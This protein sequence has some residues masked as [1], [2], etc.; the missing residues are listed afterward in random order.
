MTEVRDTCREQLSA[1]KLPA[2]GGGGRQSRK[3]LMRLSAVGL[4]LTITL[5]AAKHVVA[6]RESGQNPL[7][8]LP[9]G[10]A[11]TAG[12]DIGG[13]PTDYTLQ[14]LAQSNRVDGVVNIGEPDVAEQVAAASLNMAYMHLPMASGAAP[15]RI[16]LRTL[17][18][19]MR[20]HA[21]GGACVYLHDDAGGGRAVATAGMLLLLRGESWR[22]VRREMT[23]GELS[24]L[25]ASQ[26]TAVEQLTSA[27]HSQGHSQPGNPYS[28]SRV[29]PW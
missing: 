15:T 18:N 7:A 20:S 28:D 5:V 27:L 25:S 19:F 16:Q 21:S 2:I 6:A 3:F 23:A 13:A 29:Y 1:Q 11:V 14:A 17:A 8:W 9:A 12:L 26:S 4:L 10:Q 24:S 22:N